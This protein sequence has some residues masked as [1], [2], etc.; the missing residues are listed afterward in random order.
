M[1]GPGTVG[2]EGKPGFHFW[3]SSLE[4][5]I[6]HLSWDCYYT[7]GFKINVLCMMCSTVFHLIIEAQ[8][9]FPSVPAPLPQPLLP[10]QRKQR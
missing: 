7:E 8:H 4:K 6:S 3:F 1:L 10:F 9:S 5:L 2:K